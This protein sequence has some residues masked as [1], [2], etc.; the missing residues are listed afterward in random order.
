MP[1]L[2][3]MYPM[4]P[5]C[6]YARVDSMP[7]QKVFLE[8]SLF[9]RLSLSLLWEIPPCRFVLGTEARSATE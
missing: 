2:N 7:S 5:S 4:P 3:V 6:G 9:C 8:R 1:C